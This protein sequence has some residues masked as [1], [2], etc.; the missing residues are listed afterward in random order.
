MTISKRKVWITIAGAALA[1]TLAWGYAAYFNWWDV[2]QCAQSGGN[3]DE[4]RDECIE[5]RGADIPNTDPPGSW[6]RD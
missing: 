3:W 2:S 1:M 6:P 5:P 4:A